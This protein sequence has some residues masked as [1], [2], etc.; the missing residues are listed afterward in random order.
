MTQKMLVDGK[1]YEV[2]VDLASGDSVSIE[3]RY[4]RPSAE[5]PYGSWLHKI[6]GEVTVAT[7]YFAIE[8]PGKPSPYFHDGPPF[9]VLDT[10]EWPSEFFKRLPQS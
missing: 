3:D 1:E 8:H 5:Y 4:M 2:G 9:V 6:G 10:G 7:G